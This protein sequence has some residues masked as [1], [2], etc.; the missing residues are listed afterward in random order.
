LYGN[1]N[2]IVI[3]QDDY[4]IVWLTSKGV[5]MNVQELIEKKEQE[6]EKIKIN[7]E[8]EELKKKISELTKEDDNNYEYEIKF[9]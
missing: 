7:K 5:D 4:P 1:V 9:L 8:I 6:Q 3:V 2:R